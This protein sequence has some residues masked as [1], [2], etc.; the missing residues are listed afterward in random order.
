MEDEVAI[1]YE[2]LLLLVFRIKRN[3]EF[4]HHRN[5]IP[6]SFYVAAIKCY[7]KCETNKH[8]STCF[9]DRDQMEKGRRMLSQL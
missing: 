1:C 7:I 5:I 3:G 2:L 4:L 8:D 9:S 6:L